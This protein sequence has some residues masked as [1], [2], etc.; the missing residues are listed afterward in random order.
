VRAAAL[1]LLAG[2]IPAV[3]AAQDSVIVID[4]D[5]PQTD[6]TER[7]ALPPHIL[8]ELLQVYND[9][10]TLRLPGG[11]TLPAGSTLTG[12]IAVFRGPMR[13]AGEINGSLT[14]INGDLIVDSGGVIHGNVLV[15]GGGMTVNPG[16]Y[17]D[18]EARIFLDAAAVIRQPDGTL[19]PRERRRPIGELATAQRSFGTGKVRATV[20]LTTGQTYNRIEGLP[21]VF[22][23]V[24]EYRPSRSVLAR[25][26]ARGILRT[27][28]N[29]SPFRDDFGYSVRADIRSHAPTGFGIGGRLYSEIRGIEEHTLPRDEIGW[30]AFLL[31]RDNRDY[32]DAKGI[33][34]SAYVFPNRHLRFEASVRYDWQGSVR[35]TDPFSL[36][37]NEDSWRANPLIDDGHYTTFGLGTEYDTRNAS[38]TSGWWLRAGV[39]HSSSNDVAPV[40][41]ST[42]VRPAIPTNGYAFDRLTMDLR[43][44]NRLS[45]DDRFNIRLWAGGWLGGDPLPVQRRLSL[46]GLDVVPGYAFRAFT[47]AAPNS[48]DP[49]NAAL[50]DRAAF[51]QGEFRHRLPF[52]LGYTYRDREHQELDRFLGFDEIYLVVLGDLGKSWLTGDGPGRVPNNR[53]PSL[54]EWKADVGLG[55][56]AG[57]VGAYIAKAVTDG[58]PVRFFVRLARRF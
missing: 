14:V 15:A 20:K 53:I 17:H 2:L 58:E 16:G 33:L 43:R 6:S 21:I 36:F 56:D 27:A 42:A 18:G 47:C 39:E 5:A 1:L 38:T 40:T 25:L 57:W 46:G 30:S 41:L 11:L 7:A 12:Q 19:A 54:D 52:Q 32:F 29:D 45:A 24:I 13:V 51:F 44:Y 10:S 8:A 9:S 34:G 23:P 50:C 37:R 48:Q 22:G 26:D 28:G 35:A 49:S 4:P 55:F 31:Q 3:A